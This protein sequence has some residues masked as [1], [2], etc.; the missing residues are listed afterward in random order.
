MQELC[1]SRRLPSQHSSS[2]VV[3][4]V[5][6]GESTRESASSSREDGGDSLLDPKILDAQK[7]F[8]QLFISQSVRKVDRDLTAK[9]HLIECDE[10]GPKIVEVGKSLQKAPS[11]IDVTGLEQVSLC[12]IY[13]TYI[14]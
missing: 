5:N 6:A 11:A 7:R 12:F 8:E 4:L 10:T 14:I 1:S 9:R 3:D 13:Y 2:D